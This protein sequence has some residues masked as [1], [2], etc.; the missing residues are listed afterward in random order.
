MENSTYMQTFKWKLTY[1]S[2]LIDKLNGSIQTGL[3]DD[4]QGSFL[5]SLFLP[6]I[7]EQKSGKDILRDIRFK[8]I[9]S[10]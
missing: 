8:I 5:F 7:S 10:P 2:A 1:W 4:E 3:L 9:E 6:S